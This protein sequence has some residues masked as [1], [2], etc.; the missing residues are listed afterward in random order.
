[1]LLAAG[2]SGVSYV[3]GT[4]NGIVADCK[5]GRAVT[6]NLYV[7]WAV[8]DRGNV[9][10]VRVIL[11]D[12]TN[13]VLAS[14]PAAIN[15][16]LPEFEELLEKGKYL[17][18]LRIVITLH[19]TSASRGLVV[20]PFSAMPTASMLLHRRPDGTKLSGLSN[21]FMANNSTAALLAPGNSSAVDLPIDPKTGLVAPPQFI[22]GGNEDA[23]S[24]TLC[25]SI[26]GPY[27]G[28]D[29]NNEKN[30]FSDFYAPAPPS[31]TTKP[32]WRSPKIEIASSPPIELKPGRPQYNHTLQHIIESEQARARSF[33]ERFRMANAGYDDSGI[34][35]IAVGACGPSAMVASLRSLCYGADGVEF[36]AE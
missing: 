14:F 26:D 2:G 36:H 32:S 12:L 8:R 19:F 16:I 34:G 18:Q 21:S 6:R 25:G 22:I 4:A 28:I 5:A 29:L 15:D 31:P 33:A 24:E 27:D 23:R 17:P 35:R 9:P 11:T 1:M 7:V 13:R 10:T 30:P 20:R 3:L